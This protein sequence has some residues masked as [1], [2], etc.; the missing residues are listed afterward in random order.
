MPWLET[1]PM[2]QRERFIRD[3]R[4]DLY[5]MTELSARYGVSGKTGYKWLDRFDRGGQAGLGDR[6]R[7]PRPCPHKISKEVA[8]LIWETRRQHP[9]W[10]P[11]KLLDWISPRHPAVDL[12]AVSTAGDLPARKGLGKK[13]PPPPPYQHPRGGP[14]KTVHPNDLWTPGF[15]SHLRTPAGG[16]RYPLPLS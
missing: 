2:E 15:K 6:S 13:P 7:A 3:H 14:I 4:L 12:P 8:H 11:D 1:A 10:G 5:T 9:A 16:A